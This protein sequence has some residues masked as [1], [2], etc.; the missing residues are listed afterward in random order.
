[1][2]HIVGTPSWYL[3]VASGDRT[4]LIDADQMDVQDLRAAMEAHQAGWSR[5]LE[6]DLDPETILREVDDHDGFERHLPVGIQL[7]QALHHGSDHRSQVCTALTTLGLPVPDIDV[8]AFGLHDGRV[9]E[10]PPT[11]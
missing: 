4:H 2:R 6:K 7:A 8:W 3:F 9:I 5:L 1:M 10:L 11:S